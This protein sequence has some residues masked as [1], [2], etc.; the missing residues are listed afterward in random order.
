MTAGAGRAAVVTPGAPAEA[1]AERRDGAAAEAHDALGDLLELG[2]ESPVQVPDLSA[3]DD[4]AERIRTVARG[5]FAILAIPED[6][7]GRGC[8][9][10]E[11]A[12]AQRRLA[13]ESP[14]TAIAL[15]MHSLTVGLM[16]DYWQRHRDT[17]WML[18][19]GMANKHALVASAFA[20]PGGSS[21]FLRS[22][23]VARPSGSDYLVSGTKFPCSLATTAE[24]FCVS[25]GVEGT[26]ESIVGLCPAG[27]P[28]LSVKGS[29]DSVGMRASDTARVVLEDAELDDKLVFHRAPASDVDDLVIAG[30]VWF[31]VLVT[32]TYHGAL[33]RLYELA[34]E[35]AV[36]RGAAAGGQ[37]QV[38][39]GRAARELQ[40]LG[41]AC[42]DLARR[43]EEG[44][45]AGRRALAAAMALRASLSDARERALAALTPVLG[46]KL[47]TGGDPAA[48]FQLDSLAVH[49][50]PPN[51]LTCDEAVGAFQ[52][53]RPMSFDPTG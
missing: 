10:A 52:L 14:S 13:I 47:Y 45:V 5:D 15:N 37:R 3:V 23:S 28:G 38:L 35:A 1:Q 2:W 25:A 16:T 50:H 36:K 20:E 11:V 29:W 6:F 33:T 19:E 46:A 22:R 31:A 12:A 41:S 43:W 17:S 42:L 9:L 44:G 21:N 27:T 34:C 39:L 32:G 40:V 49:H 53:G 30:V 8:T 26:D 24:I 7:G 4:P 51:L 18:L 48:S